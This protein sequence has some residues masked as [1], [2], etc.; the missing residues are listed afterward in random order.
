M[1][2]DRELKIPMK[3][4]VLDASVKTIV[5]TAIK[6]QAKYIPGITYEVASFNNLPSEICTILYKHNITSVLIEG[7]TKTLQYFIAD[8]LWDEARIFKGDTTFTKGINAPKIVGKQI[9]KSELLNDKLMILRN[10]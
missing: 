4:H 7:G 8:G 9:S 3:F 6:N 1:I 2:I 5:I 10:D